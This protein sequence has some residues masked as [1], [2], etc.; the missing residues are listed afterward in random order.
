MKNSKFSPRDQLIKDGYCIFKNVLSRKFIQQLFQHSN[1][2][3]HQQSQLEKNELRSLGSLISL[4]KDPF[5]YSLIAHPDILE[6]MRSVG[7]EEIRYS[8]G[9]LLAKPPHSV[10]TFWHQDWWLWSDHVS[11]S[12]FIPQIGVLCYLQDVNKDN[13]ALRVIPKSHHKAHPLHHILQAMD[14]Q[15]LRRAENINTAPYLQQ[16]EEIALEVN[17]GD[18]VFIDARLL[19]GAYAN[20]SNQY[21]FGLTL[22]YYPNYHLFSE[23]IKARIGTISLE[24]SWLKHLYQMQPLLPIYDGE[25]TP[26]NIANHPQW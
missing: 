24:K 18:I 3:V 26:E 2:L 11:Y 8:N 7:A 6:K 5:F 25:A 13:G 21:R 14:N 17:Q 1:A 12:P 23:A 4:W 15:E 22:W 16:K 10:P 9:Y 19:H 20:Q